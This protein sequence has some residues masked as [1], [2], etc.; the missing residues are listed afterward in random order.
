MVLWADYFKPEHIEKYP[1]LHEM[2]WKA[3]RQASACKRH[4]DPEEGRKLVEQI[5][6]I[7][8]IFWETKQA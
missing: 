6:G 3:I 2:F 4:L 5:D 7:A 8:K 1:E